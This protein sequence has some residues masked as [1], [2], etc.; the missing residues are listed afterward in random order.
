L[1]GCVIDVS[2]SYYFNTRSDAIW[3]LVSI[4]KVLSSL[5]WLVDS[6]LYI[7]ASI[8]E[9]ED[10][11]ETEFEKDVEDDCISGEISLPLVVVTC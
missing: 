6:V 3:R 7:L 10:D 8:Y 9:E 11:N 2:L 4:G 5:L 1:I